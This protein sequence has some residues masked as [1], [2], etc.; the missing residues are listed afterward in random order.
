MQGKERENKVIVITPK[1]SEKSGKEE[2]A[3]EVAAPNTN[4][5]VATTEMKHETRENGSHR[6]DE[7][8][9]IRNRIRNR[10]G[11]P[12]GEEILPVKMTVTAAVKVTMMLL[13]N[14][15]TRPCRGTKVARPNEKW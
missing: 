7:R 8:N 11:G 4:T 2:A 15:R 14:P 9:R 10:D 6:D 13:P 3:A 5:S 1:K 12:H